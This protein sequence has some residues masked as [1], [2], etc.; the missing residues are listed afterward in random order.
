MKR[1]IY[2]TLS[3]LIIL[4]TVIP[5]QAEPQ[6]VLTAQSNS[7]VERMFE[8]QRVLTEDIQMIMTQMK[9]MMAEMKVLTSMPSQ[10]MVTMNDVYKQ[11]QL[12]AARMDALIGRTRFD[13]IQPRTTGSATIQEVYQQQVDMVAEMK[14]MM[15]E[16]KRMVTVYRG[17]VTELR[18]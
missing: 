5:V 13:T 15:A 18:Q 16:M 11:Q 10:Q 6:S 7:T 2:G 9:R 8:Q 12:L 4:S 14:E 3:S 1:L 17:R